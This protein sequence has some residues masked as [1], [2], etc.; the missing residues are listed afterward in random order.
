[1]L[2]A[3][4]WGMVVGGPNVDGRD[5]GNGCGWAKCRCLQCGAEQDMQIGIV[6]WLTP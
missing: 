5:V 6:H 1:M 2:M 3:E 4:T